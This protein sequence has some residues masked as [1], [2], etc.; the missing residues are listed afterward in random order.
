LIN[1]IDMQVLKNVRVMSAE[2]YQTVKIIDGR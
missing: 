1:Y 2:F